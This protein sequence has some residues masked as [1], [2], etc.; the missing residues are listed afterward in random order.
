MAYAP[1]PA[2]QYIHNKEEIDG[3]VFKEGMAAVE[4]PVALLDELPLKNDRREVSDRLERLERSI[5]DRGYVPM[6]PI[7]ARIGQKGRWIVIDGGHRITA[8]R[9][10]RNE[11]WTN[12]FGRKIYT[13]YFLLFETPRSWSKMKRARKRRRAS[14]GRQAIAKPHP[15][16][17]APRQ[18]RPHR[19]R[20]ASRRRP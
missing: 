4:V 14:A 18:T 3:I 13:L 7:I 8:A 9:R 15:F 6:E 12:L 16:A 17:V 19:H 11:F 20:P 5:R 10:I 1:A 2:V